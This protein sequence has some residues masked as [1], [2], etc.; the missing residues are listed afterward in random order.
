MKPANAAIPIH[1]NFDQMDHSAP[2]SE[3][4]SARLGE[5]REEAVLVAHLRRGRHVDVDLGRGLRAARCRQREGQPER[6]S[7]G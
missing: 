2:M 7:D 4:T 1:C 6:Q 5:P 3:A